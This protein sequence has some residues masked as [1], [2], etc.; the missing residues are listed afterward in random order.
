MFHVKQKKDRP[1]VDGLCSEQERV[2]EDSKPTYD[3]LCRY[4]TALFST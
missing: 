3:V 4:T 2:G 1:Q